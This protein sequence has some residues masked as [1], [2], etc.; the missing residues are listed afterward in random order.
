MTRL[1][2]TGRPAPAGPGFNYPDVGATRRRPLPAAYHHL[3][4]R[5]RIG[6]GRAVFEAA[7][8]AVCGFAMHRTTGA[9]VRA[10]AR[11]ARPG[12]RVDIGL[13]FGPMR[14]TVPCRVLWTPQEPDL[15]GFA[16]G[17]LTGHPEAGEES[18]LVRL[19]GDGAVWFEVTAFSRPGVW[20]T[21]LAGPVVPVLQ[22][23]YARMLGRALRKLAGA[24]RPA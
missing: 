18:F 5:T 15:A 23:A 21:R 17:T 24:A 10:G 14:I 3:H 12:T 11:T 9:I 8:A 20:Y 1:L 13:G 6:Y 16:Y 2:N 7:G 4:H 22:K 19:D